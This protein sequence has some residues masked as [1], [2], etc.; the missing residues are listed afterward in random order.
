MIRKVL[1]CTYCRG[2]DFEVEYST[3]SADGS[4]EIDLVCQRCGHMTMVAVTKG[5][6][7]GIDCVNEPRDIYYPTKQ[8]KGSEAYANIVKIT[9]HA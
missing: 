7:A 1:E 9:P 8:V 5:F 6:Y 3:A 4:W 2:N